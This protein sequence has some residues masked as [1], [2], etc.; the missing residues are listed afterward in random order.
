MVEL[1][2]TEKAV[3]EIKSGFQ[4]KKRMKEEVLMAN[5]SRIAD[6]IG[7][8][9]FEVDELAEMY[10]K[11]FCSKSEQY[12]PEINPLKGIFMMGTVGAGKSANFKIYRAIYH[13][14]DLEYNGNK[15][16]PLAWVNNDSFRYFTAKEIETQAYKIGEEFIETLSGVS[17][18]VIDDLGDETGDFYKTGR[19]VVADIINHRYNRMRDKGLVTHF[20]TNLNKADLISRYGDRIFDRITEMTLRLV[21]PEHLISRRK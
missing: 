9:D 14:V 13:R 15:F 6:E 10:I 5:W 21:V 18:L 4:F 17:N 19:N 11:F 8:P 2:N 7:Y 1:I 20:T 12:Y 3:T 16:K